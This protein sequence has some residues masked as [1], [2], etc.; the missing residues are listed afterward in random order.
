MQPAQPPGRPQ[1]GTRAGQPTGRPGP[2]PSATAPAEVPVESADEP[3]VPN[4]SPLGFWDDEQPTRW[5]RLRDAA[6]VRSVAVGVRSKAMS[7]RMSQAIGAVR[8]DPRTPQRAGAAAIAGGVTLFII[9]TVVTPLA[10]ADIA[11]HSAVTK[12]SSPGLGTVVAPLPAPVV[13][14][15]RKT[16]KRNPT[17]AATKAPV[18]HGVISG[19][20]ANGIP[21]VA[22]NAYR[23]AAARMANTE[24]GC[25]VPWYLLA[26]IGREESDH[27]RFGG[28]TLHADGVS[29]PR[30]IGPALDG[31]KW[32]YIPAPGNGAELAGDTKFAH[33]LGPMQFIPSTWGAYGADATGDG[34]ADIFNI[35]DAALGA[36]RYLC[37]AGGNLRTQAGQVRAVLT[38]NH[39][40]QYVAQ[41]LALA[42]AY[43]RGVPITGI[44]KGITTGKLPKVTDTGYIPPANPA[45]PTAADRETK[46][47]Q[48]KAAQKK[49]AAKRGSTSKSTTTRA[50][51]GGSGGGAG[52][53]G[54]TRPSATK[55]GASS[56]KTTSTPK[57]STSSPTPTPALT[58]C[59]L[60]QIAAGE[61][62]K[63]CRFP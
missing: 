21:R 58:P 19:L 62:G 11:R 54:G 24:P 1:P 4:T 18:T 44:P 55:S 29:T 61:A 52:G 14:A 43:R 31:V 57:P 53:G 47:A 23:V 59:T 20:A 12:S 32:D 60:V 40:D 28:A 10:G 49:A 42:D 41:V 22:L 26:G 8:T 7:A 9:G 25:G 48:K 35:N 56:S 36:A 16:L 30:I 34:K 17:H 51:G 63:T 39:N 5:S 27:G 46:A 45:A 13:P 6:G 37:A 33:A 38:Y 2:G 3:Y 50:A 15:A